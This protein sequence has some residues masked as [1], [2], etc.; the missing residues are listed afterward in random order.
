MCL[1]TLQTLR[2]VMNR[3]AQQ[4]REDEVP[5]DCVWCVGVCMCVWVC[6]CMGVCGWVG[7]VDVCG[8]GC[9]QVGSCTTCLDKLETRGTTYL[10][11][12]TG[13]CQWPVVS[14]HC[15]TRKII[16]LGTVLR[17]CILSDIHVCVCAYVCVCVMCACVCVYVFMHV[18]L[19][20]RVA[21]ERG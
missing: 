8:C 5:C 14:Q 6:G 3:D 20:P 19:V 10:P 15:R 11:S 13:F 1:G 12:L 16:T 7:C 9:M 4:E 2:C 18:S 17:T 21:C